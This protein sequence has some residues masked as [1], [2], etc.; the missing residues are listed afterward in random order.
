MIRIKCPHCGKLLGINDTAAGTAALC[1]ACKQ[2][3]RVPGV[4]AAGAPGANA[5][6]GGPAKA[7][8]RAPAKPPDF[9]AVEV[10]EEAER[11][12]RPPPAAR[13]GKRPLPAE[14]EEEV[15]ELDYDDAETEMDEDEDRPRPKKLS[16]KKKK[17]RGRDKDSDA[18][19]LRNRI[20]GS[21]GAVGGI[22]LTLIGVA[23]WLPDKLTD[24]E[25]SVLGSAAE[26]SWLAATI[27]G[28]LMVMVGVFY[29]FKTD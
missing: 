6:A 25:R 17:K 1:P 10:D 5:P 23:K 11:A 20:V 9:P 15:A 24:P 27:F 8:A 26:Y 13:A 28:A 19:V 12:R 29:I 21:V 3:F 4:K 18:M 16:P 7:P 14:E 2:K 22:V